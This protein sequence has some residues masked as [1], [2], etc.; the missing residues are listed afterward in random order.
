MSV[1]CSFYQD[2]THRSFIKLL[3]VTLSEFPAEYLCRV[4][5]LWFW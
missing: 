5:F 4:P 3:V 2:L 1:L